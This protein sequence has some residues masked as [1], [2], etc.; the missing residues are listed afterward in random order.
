MIKGII[1]LFT[2]GTLTNPMVLAGILT[3]SVLYAF[4]DS[5]DI[6][7]VYQ[8]FSFYGMA[9]LFATVYTIGFRRVYYANGETNWNETFLALLGGVFKFVVASLLMMSFISLFDM[10]DDIKQIENSDF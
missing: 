1:A 3:G 8:S 5:N 10:G 6:F 9:F 2:S 7:G 4:F